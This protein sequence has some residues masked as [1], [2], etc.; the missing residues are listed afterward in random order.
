MKNEEA[1]NT[2][3]SEILVFLAGGSLEIS[4]VTEADARTYFGIVDSENETSETQAELTV[5]GS[6]IETSKKMTIV[7][8]K[9]NLP[10]SLTFPPYG[11]VSSEEH[12][13]PSYDLSANLSLFQTKIFKTFEEKESA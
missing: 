10:T 5:Q 2:E 8:T 13:S 7:C 12:C 6:L 3:N 1:L 9:H 4:D 11:N